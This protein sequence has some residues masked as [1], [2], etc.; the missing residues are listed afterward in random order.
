MDLKC[1]SGRRA[2]LSESSLFILAYIFVLTDFFFFFPEGYR[3]TGLFYYITISFAVLFALL[4]QITYS[5]IINKVFFWSSFGILFFVLGFRDVSG[6]D[7]ATYREIFENVNRNGVIATFLFSTM[8]PGYLVL[9]YLVGSLT[10]NYYIFQIL[11]T[12]IPLFLFY[13]GFEKYRNYISIPWAVLLLIST[14]Y[15]Q[16]LAVSLVRLFIAVGIIFYFL[17]TLWTCKTRKYIFIVFLAASIHYSAL[18]MG[19]FVILTFHEK[20]LFRYWKKLILG[21]VLFL[22]FIFMG[23]SRFAAS[24][25]G[26]RYLRYTE[27]SGFSLSL[28]ALDT[29]PFLLFSLFY[30]R[31]IPPVKR[32]FYLVAVVMLAMSSVC[33]LFSTMVPLGRVIFYMNLSLLLLLPAV[34]RYAR[35]GWFKTGVGCLI[36]VYAILY[37]FVTQ[38]LN[39]SQMENLYPYRN[40]FFTI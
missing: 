17:D 14:L 23:V 10:D 9:N 39:E 7:D 24:S 28:G 35:N 22:P 6:I 1:Y 21:A 2:S 5:G 25:M 34:I 18:I 12:F 29:L 38:F 20:I 8:E 37:L 11:C 19:M 36:I 32:G 16:M 15:F 31:L 27:V 33:A 4:S 26:D 40:I 13:K 30:K 3:L